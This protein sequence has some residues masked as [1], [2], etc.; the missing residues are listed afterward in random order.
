MLGEILK[1]LY[2]I[3]V[4][5]NLPRIHTYDITRRISKGYSPKSKFIGVLLAII[6]PGLGYVYAGEILY[7]IGVFMM[8]FSGI[9]LGGVGL[10]IWFFSVIKT[11]YAI[12]SYNHEELPKK[13]FKIYMNEKKYD[14]ILKRNNAILESNPGNIHALMMCAEASFLMSEYHDAIRYYD[15]ILHNDEKNII[16]LAN[17]GSALYNLERYDEA[18]ECYDKAL[19]LKPMSS[20]LNY[21]LTNKGYIYLNY[22][23]YDNAL[24]CY[25]EAERAYPSNITTWFGKGIALMAKDNYLGAIGCFNKVLSANPAYID[26]WTNMGYCLKVVGRDKDSIKC[27]AEADRLHVLLKHVLARS[28]FI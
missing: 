7:G 6:W 15:R 17:K 8:V 23:D 2:D 4:V 10:I 28:C 16:A 11:Y 5:D 13:Y 26:G 1:K 20:M 3:P 9:F 22:K 12:A 27:Y 21:I 24:N 25:N 14:R 19:Q 18:M